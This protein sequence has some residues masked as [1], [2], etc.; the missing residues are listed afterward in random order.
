MHRIHG[1]DPS[2]PQQ[3]SKREAYKLVLSD[4]SLALSSNIIKTCEGVVYAMELK[5]EL[6]QSGRSEQS[7]IR[8][9]KKLMTVNCV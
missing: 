4:R 3:N 8:E 1:K 6:K 2:E 9:I 7:Q 5:V